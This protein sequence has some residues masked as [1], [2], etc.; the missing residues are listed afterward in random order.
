MSSAD[1]AI[2]VLKLGG[3]ILTGGDAVFRAVRE[4]HDEVSRRRRVVAVVSAEWGA[5]D[6]LDRLARRFT[7]GADSTAY[8]ALLATGEARSAACLTLALEACDLPVVLL[9]THRLALRTAGPRTAAEPR[10]VGPALAANLE[11]ASVVVVP[12]FVGFHEDGST[13]LLGRG[14]TDLT[15]VFLAHHLGAAECR[16]LKDVAGWFTADPVVDPTARPYATL[17]W[18]DAVASRAPIVQPR[19]VQLARR[20]DRPFT[21]AALGGSGGT[22]VGP[23]ATRLA[24]GARHRGSDAAG[25]PPGPSPSRDTLLVHPPSVPGEPSGAS[26]TPIYQTATFAVGLAEEGSSAAPAWDYSRSGNPTRDVLEA[27]LAALEGGGSIRALTYNSGV[28]ALSATLGL[29]PPGGEV[30]VGDDL[31]GG[32]RRLLARLAEHLGVR[33]VPVDTTDPDAVAAA[34]GDRT[35]LLLVESP[36]NPRLR[37][38]PVAVLAQIAHRHGARLAVDNSLL[39]SQLMQPLALGADLA[40]QSAT[41]L[42]GGHG[43]LTAGV[44]AVQD[45]ELAERLAFERNAEGSALAPFESWLLLRGLQTLAV[46]LDRQLE[47]ARRV[48]AFLRAHPRVR[49]VW[50]PPHGPGGVVTSFET[51]S[52]AVSRSIVQS[53]RLFATTVSFGAARSSISLPAQMSH[54]CVPEEERRRQGLAPD[55]VRLSVGIEDADDLLADLGRVLE[56][57][58]TVASNFVENLVSCV[59]H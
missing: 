57:A 37:V 40:I 12:G 50:Y 14:G 16:L 8:T 9:E 30:V 58:P 36:S 5:T 45:G 10:S 48:V 46:R 29:V 44:I 27:Q 49:R 51:G 59:G 43:D 18:D 32:T 35:D 42:L 3:S 19:A 26:S 33:V 34:L 15:A 20:L 56:G 7:S 23:W 25:P 2:T 21:V 28:A 4:I 1:S 11:R 47:T 39:S 22:R 54:A 6:G 52:E 17:H 13:T 55:L 38:S 53:T 24:T 41:K 31:Y